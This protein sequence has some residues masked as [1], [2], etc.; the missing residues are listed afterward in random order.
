MM[1]TSQAIALVSNFKCHFWL[2]VTS[3]PHSL[4]GFL[5]ACSTECSGTIQGP[6]SQGRGGE[7]D[8]TRHSLASVSHLLWLVPQLSPQHTLCRHHPDFSPATW[9]SQPKLGSHSLSPQF[10]CP[11]SSDQRLQG[12]TPAWTHFTPLSCPHNHL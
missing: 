9:T 1:K 5:L 6:G 8:H 2:W 12:C 11:Q 3:Q 7:L 10:S 4:G